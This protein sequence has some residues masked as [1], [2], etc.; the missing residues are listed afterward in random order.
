VLMTA[1]AERRRGEMTKREAGAEGA[2]DTDRLL[3]ARQP[4]FKGT[5]PRRFFR[6]HP[7]VQH[8]GRIERT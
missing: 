5:S 2:G 4:R 1:P 6:R 8:G 7:Q 3:Q